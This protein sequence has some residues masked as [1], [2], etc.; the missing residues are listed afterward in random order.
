[1]RFSTSSWAEKTKWSLFSALVSKASLATKILKEST[2]GFEVLALILF[3]LTSPILVKKI[4]VQ[5][6]SSQLASKSWVKYVMRLLEEEVFSCL[7]FLTFSFSWTL[8]IGFSIYSICMIPANRSVVC[9]EDVFLLMLLSNEF[10]SWSVEKK[11]SNVGL[12][13]KSNKKVE[14]FL[15]VSSKIRRFLTWITLFCNCIKTW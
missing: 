1:M 6:G 14:F 7:A 3:L 12:P 11:H 4:E 13:S 15:L 5:A 10:L 2:W 9:F 8:E